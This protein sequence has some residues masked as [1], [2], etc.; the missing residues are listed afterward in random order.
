MY[1]NVHDRKRARTRS[2]SPPTSLDTR[3]SSDNLSSEHIV[4][5]SRDS[6]LRLPAPRTLGRGGTTEEFGIDKSRWILRRAS[7]PPLFFQYLSII[8][9]YTRLQVS[10]RLSVHSQL[11]PRGEEHKHNQ[12]LFLSFNLSE[13]A[14]NLDFFVTQFDSYI[15]TVLEYFVK[16]YA[17]ELQVSDPEHFVQL[18]SVLI[19]WPTHLSGP[20]APV[21][22]FSLASTA[23]MRPARLASSLNPTI[24]HLTQ[25]EIDSYIDAKFWGPMQRGSEAVAKLLVVGTFPLTLHN[26]QL[27]NLSTEPAMD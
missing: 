6:C 21:T 3:F 5:S 1:N 7:G 10:P 12:H 14:T 16:R 20:S 23:T 18:Q 22:L 24:D 27:L 13:V 19:C 26:L 2:L 25:Q 11:P 17:T 8:M 15:S 9:T 4:L